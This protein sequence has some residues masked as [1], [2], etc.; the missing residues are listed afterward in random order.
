MFLE[1]N[2]ESSVEIFKRK[3]ISFQE[4]LKFIHLKRFKGEVCYLLRVSHR[5]KSVEIA[6][7]FIAWQNEVQVT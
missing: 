2:R 7:L 6:F 1:E 3:G 5:P 4:W